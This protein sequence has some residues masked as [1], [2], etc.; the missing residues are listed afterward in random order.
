M[1]VSWW[2][3]HKSNLNSMDLAVAHNSTQTAV[4]K[5]IK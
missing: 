2:K 3:I 4:A 1:A 5:E